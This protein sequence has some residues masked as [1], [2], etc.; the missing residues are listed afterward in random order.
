MGKNNTTKTTEINVRVTAGEKRRFRAAARRAGL[1]MS[2]WLRE[3][4]RRDSVKTA[5]RAVTR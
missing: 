2:A 1:S 3:L 4:A 5:V